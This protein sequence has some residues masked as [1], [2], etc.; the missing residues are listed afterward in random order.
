M[1]KTG[2]K[3]LTDVAT[4]PFAGGMDTRSERALVPP[5]TYS[6]IQNIRHRHTG[7]EQRL[8]MKRKHSTADSTNQAMSLYQF[9]K[10]R[11][12]ERHF[13][14]QM[15]DGDVLKATNAP[16]TVT[17]GAFGAEFHSGTTK[18][19][20]MLPASW[21][22]VNDILIYSNGKE[23]HQVYA[24]DDNYVWALIKYDHASAAPATVPTNGVDYTLDVTD[25]SATTGATLDD[26]DTLAAY[27]CLFIC[28]PVPATK[29]TWTFSGTKVNTAAAVGTLSYRKDDNTWAD[30]TETDG[31]I[32]GG[33]TTLGQSGSMTWSQ[34]SDEIPCYMYGQSGY[35][36]QWKTDTQLTDA[37]GI[38]VT[39]VTYGHNAEFIDL[40]NVW[41]GTL[42][43]IVEAQHFD[44]SATTDV[45]YTYPGDNI[46]LSGFEHTNDKLFFSFQEPLQGVYID[47]GIAPNNPDGATAINAIYY[48]TG[49]A[50]AS[51][52][53]VTDETNGFINS[54]WITWAQKASEPHQFN[55][56]EYYA[57]WYY[58]VFETASFSSSVAVGM[59]GMPYYDISELGNVSLASCSW[60][61]RC[62][63][64]FD[65]YP[66]YVYLPSN[67][68]P[69]MLN[70]L[71]YGI[72][73]AGDGRNNRV[74]AM[75]RFYNEML[76]WQ[77]EKG[78][79]GGCTTLFQGYSPETYGKLVLSSNVGTFSNK[80]VVVVDGVR[81]TAN[82]EESSVKSMAFWLSNY[83]VIAS[84]G[85]GVSIISDQIQNYFDP[86]DS[87][88]IRRGYDVEHWI[89]YD[90]MYN[91]LRIGLVT[92]STSAIPNTFLTFDLVEGAWSHDELFADDATAGLS[93]V[94]EVEAASG[95]IPI[96][97]YGGG[98]DDGCIYQLNTGTDDKD[99][100]DTTHAIDA[101]AT[102]EL[103][104][105]G[106]V[107]QVGRL[108]L[109]TK[110]QSA[111]SV[112]VTPSKNGVEQTALGALSM[113]A[114]NT[115]ELMRRNR[116]KVGT[117][118][119]NVSLKFQ[120]ATAGQSMYLLDV[121]MEVYEKS[122][123]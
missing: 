67:E 35:W 39:S 59:K 110:V 74:I 112:T 93:C 21:S 40:T 79:D 29:L 61:G 122:S 52:G 104:N 1:A 120:N 70:G 100:A 50:W 12:A 49:A 97:Q 53:T 23:Q 72:L 57:H 33:D 117:Q 58:I 71:N 108:V 18:A 116:T 25:G 41:D 115:N 36:Y 76:V 19:S 38:T 16:P 10:G 101:Y 20:G 42:D 82:S 87:N 77:Q 99:V 22:D 60:K 94:T 17:T 9:S 3:Q 30:T 113:T 65:K 27:E 78:L 109:R 95:N 28:T 5:G 31:T 92:G 45:Y 73:Q 4:I 96:L 114:E 43:Y 2:E 80:S 106:K 88:S 44:N 47:A 51:V 84:D 64:T 91:C 107:F 6:D 48:W 118:D 123:R 102:M 11:T 83:G 37:A 63:M 69:L 55:G 81:T 15:S 34:P 68:S 86:A 46:I 121:G 90:S 89:G 75:R 105:Q 26:L 24:G 13:F 103:S 7:F 62:A 54:G 56:S 14:A 66:S 85:M 111:G 98:V 119:S 32:T 8:G